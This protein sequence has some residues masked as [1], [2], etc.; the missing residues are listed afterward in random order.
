MPNRLPLYPLY[1][2]IGALFLGLFLL[3]GSV[4]IALGYQATLTQ[5]RL[6]AEQQFSP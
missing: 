2:H 5:S 3:F 4:L 6:Q 1:I